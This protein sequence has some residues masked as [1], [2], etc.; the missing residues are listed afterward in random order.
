[1]AAVVTRLITVFIIAA[2][3]AFVFK[4]PMQM[5]L[6]ALTTTGTEIPQYLLA[7]IIP[8]GYLFAFAVSGLILSKVLMKEG[9]IEAGAWSC[10]MVAGLI[11]DIP[12]VQELMD[13]IMAEAEDIISNQMMGMLGGK[14]PA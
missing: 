4:F 8:A 12:T 3:I 7:G 6:K 5:G 11:H 13:R 14:V 2:V 1:M 10:G 9:D